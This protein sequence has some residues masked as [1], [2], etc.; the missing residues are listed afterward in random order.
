MLIKK[1]FDSYAKKSGLVGASTDNINMDPYDLNGDSLYDLQ[2][3]DLD[4]LTKT[5]SS[6]RFEISPRGTQSPF[7][8]VKRRR[9]TSGNNV[10]ELFLGYVST[11]LLLP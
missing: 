10:S 6:P 7:H 5:F 1:S 8:C 2:V 4:M 3:D 11:G 9:S